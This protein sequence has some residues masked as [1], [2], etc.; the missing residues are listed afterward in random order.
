MCPINDYLT[1]THNLTSDY[2]RGMCPINDYLT[3]THNLTSDYVRGMCPI[4]D[5]LT[6]THNLTSDY[7][8]GMCPINDN[9]TVTHNL[10]SDYVRGMCPINDYLT[11]THNLTSDYVRGMCPIN[12]YLTVTHNLTFEICGAIFRKINNL[13]LCECQFSLGLLFYSELHGSLCVGFNTWTTKAKIKMLALKTNQK[14]YHDMDEL[15]IWSCVHFLYESV[16][17]RA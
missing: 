3:V 1:V 9:L 15:L 13:I 12:D 10:T 11:V 6:V 16:F 5:H 2:V 17:K 7:V 4:N 8:R 14:C